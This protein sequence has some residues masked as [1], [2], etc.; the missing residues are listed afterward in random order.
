MR[1]TGGRARGIELRLPKRGDL[2]PSTGAL[3]SAIFSSLGAT[4]VEARVLDLFAGTGAYGLEALSRGAAHVT[5]VD[6]SSAAIAAIHA[7][8]AAVAKSLGAPAPEALGRGT[9]H[10][11]FRWQ[12]AVDEKFELIF[13]DPPYALVPARGAEL[14]DRALAWLA[15]EGD[16]RLVCEAPGEYVPAVPSGWRIA[17]RLGQGRREP[18]AIIFAREIL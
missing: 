12:P 18:S 14:I 15:P 6:Q 7:N 16:V 3:R 11:A 13:I 1:I 2:R 10:D 8:L 4:V 17:R 5:W 9:A